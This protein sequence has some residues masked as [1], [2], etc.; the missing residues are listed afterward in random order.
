[1]IMAVMMP[2]EKWTDERLD[3]LDK[4]VDKGFA[5]V[6]GEIKRL[7]GNIRR[8]EGEIKRLDGNLGELRR[9][10]N[11]RFE[12]MDLRFDSLNRSLQATMVGV[13]VAL[14]GSNAFF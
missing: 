1:M 9:E 3:D 5:R 6:E 10:I 14:I 4:K 12:A 11:A 13:I 8:V 7:D 2:R